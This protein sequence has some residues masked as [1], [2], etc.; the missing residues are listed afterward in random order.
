MRRGE[1]EKQ[2]GKEKRK[3]KGERGKS[4]QRKGMKKNGESRI[5]ESRKEWGIRESVN[6]ERKAEKRVYDGS[7]D[8]KEDKQA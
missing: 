6:G 8:C 2:K 5:R 1:E 7:I 4:S 3:R